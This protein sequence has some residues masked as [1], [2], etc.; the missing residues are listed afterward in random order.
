MCPK[1]VEK[2]SL[3]PK[4]KIVLAALDLAAL[5]GWETVTLYNIAEEAGMDMAALHNHVEDKF[6]IL[7]ALGRMI[8]R[9]TL[10]NQSKADPEISVRD[11]LFDIFMDRFEVLNEH[12]A[13]IV[14][15][16]NTFKFDPKQ[17]VISAPH[18][19]RSMSWML[20]AAQVNTSGIKGGIKIA[21]IT[22]LY[23]KVLRVW[24]SDETADMS[25]TM[26]ALDKALGRAEKFA[27]TVGF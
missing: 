12:R 21:A 5:Q 6:D 15:I 2:N 13:G 18:L 20:E 14:A 25:Q 3:N 4:D 10:E 7:S 11:A 27:E 24:M 1:K 16:L 8:D 26:A 22:G 9:K 23:L 19:C 17:M